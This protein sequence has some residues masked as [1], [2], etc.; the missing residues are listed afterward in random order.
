MNEHAVPLN[1]VSAGSKA[2]QFLLPLM[3]GKPNF[4]SYF[5]DRCS[6][7]PGDFRTYRLNKSVPVLNKSVPVL[8]GFIWGLERLE[9]AKELN[10]HNQHK[11]RDLLAQVRE[12][13]FN[14]TDFAKNQIISPGTGLPAEVSV[15][16]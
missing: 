1:G 7:T 4:L 15:I 11:L 16:R 5:P 2:C 3:I 14:F 10:P 9:Y 13:E 12:T 6:Y 8:F